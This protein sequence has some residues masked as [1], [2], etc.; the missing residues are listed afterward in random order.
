MPLFD[1]SWPSY[2]LVDQAGLM[3]HPNVEK[4][5][6]ESYKNSGLSGLSCCQ[7]LFYVFA[8]GR[9]YL[10]FFSFQHLLEI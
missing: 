9:A 1:L 3:K 10:Y 4:Y 5:V 6:S 7:M 2:R 8:D